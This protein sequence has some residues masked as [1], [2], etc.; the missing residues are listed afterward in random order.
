[1]AHLTKTIQ[2]RLYTVLQAYGRLFDF[3]STLNNFKVDYHLAHRIDMKNDTEAI[4]SDWQ[5]VNNDL[6]YALGRG[7]DELD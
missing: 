6:S 1:M 7:I 5:T 3:G 2:D 4:R